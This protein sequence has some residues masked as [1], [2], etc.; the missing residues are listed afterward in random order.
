MG[1]DRIIA[2]EGENIWRAAEENPGVGRV[3]RQPFPG[4]RG[5]GAVLPGESLSCF[6]YGLE[7]PGMS[8][9][10]VVEAVKKTCRVRI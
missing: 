8:G 2:V 3:L 1:N 9:D 6:H 7:M 4:G 5:S 10:Q